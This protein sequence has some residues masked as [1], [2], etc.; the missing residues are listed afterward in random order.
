LIIS[1]NK[2][3]IFAISKIKIE[4]MLKGILAISGQPGLFKV[5]TE[6]KNNVIV[7]SLLSG[8][9][10]TV[11][12]DAKM[13]ALED[14][15]IYTTKEDLP[16]RKVLKKIAEKEN[17]GK[18][19]DAKKPPEDLKKYFAEVLPDYDKEKVYFSDI[20]KVISWYNLLHD[21]GLLDLEDD[22]EEEKEDKEKDAI[23]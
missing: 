20:K 5:L 3:T 1:F 17:G 21:K 9:R 13:S 14:I 10:S 18:A 23:A 11:Y 8:K 2:I 16:L 12:T 22:K 6:G 7:E 19:I 15:A 4:K